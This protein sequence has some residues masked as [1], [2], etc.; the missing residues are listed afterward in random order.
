M[1]SYY[2]ITMT[3]ISLYTDSNRRISRLQLLPI[4]H[5][6]IK[7]NR[8]SMDI[9]HRSFQHIALINDIWFKSLIRDYFSQYHPSQNLYKPAKY[10]YQP[11]ISISS[12]RKIGKSPNGDPKQIALVYSH[13][14]EAN[15][16][17]Y[18]LATRHSR[19][20]TTQLW[21]GCLSLFQ[22]SCLYHNR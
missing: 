10:L 21:C 1:R 19:Q 22:Y 3:I 20:L 6:S 4:D 13:F 8:A 18:S 12:V 11:S 5:S 17:C 2:R 14:G 15:K 7:T 16:F 9:A